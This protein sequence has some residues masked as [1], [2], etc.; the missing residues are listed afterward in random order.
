M[1]LYCVS[2]AK[3]IKILPSF[4]LRYTNELTSNWWFL[5]CV[6][7]SII[8]IVQWIFNVFI[9]YCHVVR[10]TAGQGEEKSQNSRK[11]WF[12]NRQHDKKDKPEWWMK[13]LSSCCFNSVYTSARL[14]KYVDGALG[15]SCILIAGFATVISEFIFLLVI[16]LPAETQQHRR[17]STCHWRNRK[18]NGCDWGWSE[19]PI[20]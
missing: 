18:Q 16:M 10:E 11:S 12:W 5:Y 14:G 4:F 20:R 3:S 13:S 9:Q 6:L 17:E 1:D 8:I 15:R 2:H 7:N 19:I